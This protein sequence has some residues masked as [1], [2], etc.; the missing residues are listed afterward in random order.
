M[1]FQTEIPFMPPPK[2]FRGMLILES[3]DGR[4]GDYT[5]WRPLLKTKAQRSQWYPFRF[6]VAACTAVNVDTIG[7]PD[8]M[9]RTELEALVADGW[10]MLNHGANHAG[11]SFHRTRRAATAG[12]TVIR[13]SVAHTI[14]TKYEYQIKS[15]STGATELFRIASVGTVDGNSEAEVTLQAPLVNNHVTSALIELTPASME[16]EI[17]GGLQT[18]RS[19][20]FEVNHYV[21][22]Y[23]YWYATTLNKIKEQHLTS[24]SADT[25]WTNPLPIPNLHRMQGALDGTFTDAQIKPFIDQLHSE[26]SI[27]IWYGHGFEYQRGGMLDKL[28][29]YAIDKGVRIVTRHEAYQKKINPN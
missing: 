18:L 12:E 13:V 3:D 25:A 6:P 4:R 14:N 28:V 20:G 17:N 2:Q 21:N 11:L 8:R 29:D 24:R 23:H 27:G 5:H 16:A 10:E 15:E 26:D 9:T 7:N 19:W 22:P 1:N